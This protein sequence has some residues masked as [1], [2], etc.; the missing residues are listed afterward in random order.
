MNK[1]LIR[2]IEKQKNLRKK[3]EEIEIELQ[4]LV[5]E[6]EEIE[7]LEVIKEFRSQKISLDEFLFIVRKNKEEEN[8]ERQE[9]KRKDTNESEENL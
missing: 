9:L 2:N 7:N 5:E 4:L 6:Q 8:R 3:K 1:K